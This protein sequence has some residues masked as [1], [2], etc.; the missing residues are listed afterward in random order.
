MYANVIIYIGK[1]T[2]KNECKGRN[3]GENIGRRGGDRKQE[4]RDK[5]RETEIKR[6]EHIKSG[7]IKTYIK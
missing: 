2:V 7:I 4:N 1:L 6:R 3:E 5:N